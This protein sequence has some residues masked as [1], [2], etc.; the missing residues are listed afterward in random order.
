MRQLADLGD[1]ILETQHVGWV[2]RESVGQHLDRDHATCVQL[3]R[4]VD[5]GHTATLYQFE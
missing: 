2:S 4:A 5:C 3:T 1:L